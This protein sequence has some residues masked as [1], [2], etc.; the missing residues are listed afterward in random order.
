MA[1]AGPALPQM[2]CGD[3]ELHG[4]ENETIHAGLDYNILKYSRN[5]PFQQPIQQLSH[6]FKVGRTKV[7]HGDHLL[8]AK[9]AHALAKTCSS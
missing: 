7:L 1:L 8:A 6:Q 5:V 9:I 3:A 4:K 2:H